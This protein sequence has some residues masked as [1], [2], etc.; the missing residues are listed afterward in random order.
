MFSSNVLALTVDDSIDATIKKNYNT[1]EIE[2]DLLPSLPKF[3]PVI[4]SSED[5]DFS[6][7]QP[8]PQSTV[9]TAIPVNNQS[10]TVVEQKPVNAN[11]NYSL[12]SQRN[13]QQPKKIQT[14]NFSNNIYSSSPVNRVK[15]QV[16]AIATKNFNY[17]YKQI[18]LR[19][20]TR[21]KLR[22][23]TS[24]SD[25]TPVGSK[26]YFVSVYPETSR[27]LTIPSGTV[28]RGQVVDSH[29]PQIAGNGG[30][31]VVEVNEMIYKNSVYYINAKVGVADYRRIYLNNIKGKHKIFK[32]IC[33]FSRPG[34][35]FMRRMW[36]VAGQ[37]SNGPE[38]VL[39][40]IAIV[41]GLVVYGTNIA[42]SPVFSIF[43][44]GDS[45]MI[46]DGAYFEIKL[47][48]D[49]LIRDN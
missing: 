39:S 2:K 4:D 48:Q 40:P 9:Q 27:Y 3:S 23:Q 10:K 25:R 49:A 21:F 15:Q 20:G 43:S 38:I 42:V 16:P 22:L 46:P 28:F 37:L 33:A 45:I 17:Q 6:N 13:A 8:Q 36:R 1:E 34:R 35:H 30:L 29:S 32:N 26:V 12:Y 31:I 14:D 19:K 44:T 24:I 47:R 41:G 5:I 11:Q 18:V 7:P